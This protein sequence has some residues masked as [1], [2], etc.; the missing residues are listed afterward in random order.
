M[1]AENVTVRATYTINQYTI[2]FDTD[3]GSE[4][5]PI[6]QNYGTEIIAPADPIKDGYTFLGWTPAVPATMPAE[7]ITLTA[8]WA[9]TVWT[10]DQIASTP[11][12]SYDAQT[13]TALYE[14]QTL[15][16]SPIDTSI[17]RTIEAAWIGIKLIAPNSVTAANK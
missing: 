9:S 10:L 6:T 16:Y 4:V 8:Q 13:S 1:P 5:A 7:D 12:T 14:D 11:W 2:T 3:G 15:T 17:G